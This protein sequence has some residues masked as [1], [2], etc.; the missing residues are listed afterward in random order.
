MLAAVTFANWHCDCFIH[1][2]NIKHCKRTSFLIFWKYVYGREYREVQENDRKLYLVLA[3][4]FQSPSI[5]EKKGVVRVDDFLQS[6]VLCSNGKGGTRGW[7]IYLLD[8]K[9]LY[10]MWLFPLHFEFWWICWFM[11][12]NHSYGYIT[13]PAPSDIINIYLN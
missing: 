9:G 10:A 13:K 5:P 11:Y 4:S 12:L 1:F 6:C 8:M 2:R 7:Y 3:K